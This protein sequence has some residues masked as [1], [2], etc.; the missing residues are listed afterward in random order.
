MG[1]TLIHKADLRSRLPK[2]VPGEELTSCLPCEE[3]QGRK[4]RARKAASIRFAAQIKGPDGL[5]H[6]FAEGT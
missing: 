1:G 4:N 5:R 2:G 3:N 6:Q